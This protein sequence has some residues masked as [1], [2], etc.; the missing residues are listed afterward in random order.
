[1]SMILAM[2]I[3]KFIWNKLKYNIHNMSH[4]LLYSSCLSCTFLLVI[5]CGRHL[6]TNST[7]VCCTVDEP[8]MSCSWCCQ[9]AQYGKYTDRVHQEIERIIGKDR[10]TTSLAAREHRG[11]D[12]SYHSCLPADVVVMPTS[13]D[14]VSSVMRLCNKERIPVIPFGTGTGLEGGVGATYVRNST[15]KLFVVKFSQ[16]EEYAWTYLG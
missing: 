1:M 6:T 5:F 8:F 3:I 15:F 10:V 4:S 9:G 13:V 16:R 11:K 14:H 12:E 7:V 2:I